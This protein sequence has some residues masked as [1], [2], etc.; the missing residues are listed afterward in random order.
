MV[1]YVLYIKNKPVEACL[2]AIRLFANPNRKIRSHSHITVRGPLKSEKKKEDL[3]KLNKKLI[4]NV[5]EIT[6]AGHFLLAHQN[7]VFFKCDSPALSAVWKKKDYHEFNP[8]IT[9]YNGNS[10]VFAKKIYEVISQYKYNI[11]FPGDQLEKYVTKSNQESLLL[12]FTFDPNLFYRILNEHIRTDTIS[13]MSDRKRLEYIDNI[14][15]YLSNNLSKNHSK[16][17]HS[18]QP[19]S[20][21][22]EVR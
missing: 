19:Y 7:T 14:C 11:S 8:H 6:G 21:I 16:L 3:E 1:F 15:Y 20:I 2:D 5:V 22:S 17:I 4:G 13:C 9:I 18:N 12:D 10:N